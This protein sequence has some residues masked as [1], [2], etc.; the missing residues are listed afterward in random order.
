MSDEVVPD[1]AD[2]HPDEVVAFWELARARAKVGRLPVVTGV[3]VAAAMTPPAWAFGDNPALADEL[4]ALVL[5]GE[6]TGTTTAVAELAATGGPEP[7]VGELSIILDGAGRPRALIRTTQVRRCRFAEV[8][9]EFAASEGE[10][11]RTLAG[12]RSDH[13]RYWRRT[14][15][16]TG[17]AVDGDLEVFAETFEL[18]HPRPARSWRARSR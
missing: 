11:D 14:L 12:W 1:D 10:G 18:L 2:G 5:A 13:E 6:K 15:A 7:W 4:L 8:D 16:G 9:A 17:V 3:D